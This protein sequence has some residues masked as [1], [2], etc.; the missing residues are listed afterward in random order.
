M[1]TNPSSPDEE[2]PVVI[3]SRYADLDDVALDPQRIPEQ[4]RHLLDHAKEWA[5]GDDAERADYMAQVPRGHLQ[6]FVNAVW[7][8]MGEIEAWCQE[9]REEVPEPDEVMLFDWMCESAA[10]AVACHV[11]PE[12]EDNE[13]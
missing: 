8:L 5:I 9:H 11:E 13:S 3:T 6:A 1:N 4:F 12:G 7:P 10:E 2:E